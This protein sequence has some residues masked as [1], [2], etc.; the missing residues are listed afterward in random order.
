[1]ITI[2]GDIHFGKNKK[3]DQ[4]FLQFLKTIKTDY[5]ILPGD[6]FH[7]YFEYKHGIYKDSLPLIF[8]LKKLKEKGVSILFVPG[9]H[10]LWTGDYIESVLS[11]L[12]PFSNVKIEGKIFHIFHYIRMSRFLTLKSIRNLFSLIPL[13]LGYKL[14]IKI[15]EITEKR[16]ERDLMTPLLSFVKDIKADFV[17]FGHLHIPVVKKLNE[18][19]YLLSPGGWFKSLTYIDIKDGVPVLKKYRNP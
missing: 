6:V 10:D 4:L 13:D 2:V 11:V 1:M 5:L 7:F 12:P 18:N 3:S 19:K 16:K 9:N 14:G 15:G 17:V 8:S